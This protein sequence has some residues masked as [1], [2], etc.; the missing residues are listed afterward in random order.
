MGRLYRERIQT[1]TLTRVA[2]VRE[3]DRVVYVAKNGLLG[4]L[5]PHFGQLFLEERIHWTCPPCFLPFQFIEQLRLCV[6][7]RMTSKGSTAQSTFITVCWSRSAW[8]SS[9]LKM[10]P[11][12][13]SRLVKNIGDPLA[14]LFCH[15]PPA[16]VLFF[17]HCCTYLY[18]CARSRCISCIIRSLPDF[19]FLQKVCSTTEAYETVWDN[20]SSSPSFFYLT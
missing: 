1:S 20:L 11:T 12:V 17:L 6:V 4:L 10:R 3:L 14:F 18:P 19:V 2:W 15:N 8:S 7:D 5:Y 16:Y 13:R 9:N